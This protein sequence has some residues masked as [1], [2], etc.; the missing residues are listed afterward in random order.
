[1]FLC[2]NIL[3][4]HLGP[5]SETRGGIVSTAQEHLTVP[6]TNVLLSASHLDTGGDTII[7]IH[8]V[9]WLIPYNKCRVV[10]MIIIFGQTVP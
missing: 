9:E 7:P 8:D 4:A 3:K 2:C 5:R 1:M 10:L 6:H